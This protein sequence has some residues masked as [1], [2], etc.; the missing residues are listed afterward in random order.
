M[1]CCVMHSE[2]PVAYLSNMESIQSYFK[3]HYLIYVN[4]SNTNWVQ[5]LSQNV[6]HFYFDCLSHCHWALVYHHQPF[7]FFSSFLQNSSWKCI[8]AIL[9]RSKKIKII[10]CHCVWVICVLII[11][12]TYGYTG[13]FIFGN[14]GSRS[15]TCWF[16]DWPQSQIRYIWLNMR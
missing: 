8:R 3:R 7:F 4:D 13:C 15:N 6:V 2:P 10:M 11:M 1:Q 5:K 14:D 9:L 12:L 16:F